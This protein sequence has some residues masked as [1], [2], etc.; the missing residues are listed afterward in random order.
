M[1][2]N[3]ATVLYPLIRKIGDVTGKVVRQRKAGT[4]KEQVCVLYSSKEQDD[5]EDRKGP[6]D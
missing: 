5:R 1:E 2:E 3:E 4:T 6:Q